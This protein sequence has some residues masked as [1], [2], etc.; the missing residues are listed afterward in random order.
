LR[1][2]ASRVKTPTSLGV[3][4]GEPAKFG[5]KAEHLIPFVRSFSHSPCFRA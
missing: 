4:E 3:G 2:A 1:K 5:R